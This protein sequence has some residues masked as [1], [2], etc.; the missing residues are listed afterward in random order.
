MEMILR[1][2]VCKKD[3]SAIGNTIAKIDHSSG[4]SITDLKEAT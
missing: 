1:F 3:F 2:Y 4:G